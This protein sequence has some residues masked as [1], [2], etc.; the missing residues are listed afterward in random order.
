MAR[1]TIAAGIAVLALIAPAGAVAGGPIGGGPAGGLYYYAGLSSLSI[2]GLQGRT[3][4]C[5]QP[6]T[7]AVGG[8]F[9]SD[10]ASAD[11]FVARS[12]PQDAD[13]DGKPDDG[14]YTEV[15]NLSGVG[16][17]FT[18]YAVCG[19]DKVRYRTAA[20]PVKAG[21][22]GTITARCPVGTRGTAGGLADATTNSVRL[23]SLYPI[24]G[25]D[26]GKNLDD[27]WAA[28]VVNTGGEK[29]KVT[30]IAT[31]TQGVKMTYLD[32]ANEIT[33]IPAND[34]LAISASVCPD[35][36]YTTGGGTRAPKAL[37]GDLS[38]TAMIPN[39]SDFDVD[40]VPDDRMYFEEVND[41]P[42]QGGKVH[43]FTA[44]LS[45]PGI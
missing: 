30:T 12:T 43:L 23:A 20:E 29:A 44:C 4:I 25:G 15:L 34:T 35:D 1:G 19:N 17:S 9:D 40:A 39:D 27:G 41:N 6:S 3:T 2:G 37:S 22:A 18:S 24:D 11:G 13:D 42:T 36:A 45:R 10:N 28:R 38:I 7:R 32:D 26:A 33:Q 31:C 21:R 16:T 5:S 14:W 8:G